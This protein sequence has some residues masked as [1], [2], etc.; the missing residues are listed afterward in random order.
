[1]EVKIL[2]AES[3]GV[4]GLCC[5]VKTGKGSA[6]V[7]PAM[8][9]GYLRDGLLPHPLQVAAGEDARQAILAELE[10][11]EDIV[12]SHFHGDHVPLAEAN[13][14]Q[15]SLSPVKE[16]MKEDGK[17]FMADPDA[18]SERG[19]ARAGDLAR[20][21]VHRVEVSPGSS[22]GH[23][24]FSL[25]V[26]HGATGSFTGVVMM[27]RVEEGHEVF[28]HGSD[29]Q[30]LSD[31]AVDRILEWEPSILLASGPPLYRELSPRDKEEARRRALLLADKIRV[32]IFDHHLMRSLE[33]EEWLDSI[34]REASGDV[35]SAA[36]FLG[37]PR[38]LLEARR[39]E[40][41]RLFPVPEG[42]HER[43]AR[44]EEDTSPYRKLDLEDIS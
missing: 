11:A 4:R 27:T 22:F 19:S 3:L 37:Q 28:V 16:A 8:A 2:S 14:F 41:Y 42:W 36:D 17:V 40:L 12:F 29:I 30:L 10:S 21:S 26:P 33:G 43:Y 1:M 32:C 35:I 38:R 18:C 13:P 20:A 25:P 39:A 5:V 34:H 23:L 24:S 7:D 31:E 15:M 6:I 44:G 9:L